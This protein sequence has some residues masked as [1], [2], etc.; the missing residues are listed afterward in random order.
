MRSRDVSSRSL[1]RVFGEVADGHGAVM[2]AFV[3]NFTER[4]D[5]G[6]ACAVYVDGRIVVDL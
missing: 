5:V 2:D 4:G 6:A 1:P 3:Q